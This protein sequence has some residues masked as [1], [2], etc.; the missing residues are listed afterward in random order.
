VV[1]CHKGKK[2]LTVSSNAA[3]AHLEHGDTLGACDDDE[4]E[5]RESSGKKNGKNGKNG[6]KNGEKNGKKNGN[7]HN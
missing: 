5:A 6:K 4:E 1:L 3:D 2:T 7:K